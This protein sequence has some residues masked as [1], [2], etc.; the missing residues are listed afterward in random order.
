ILQTCAPEQGFVL[1]PFSPAIARMAGF[2]HW[3]L[4]LQTP[5]KKSMQQWLVWGLPKLR[6]AL[7]A[8]KVHWS[9]DVDPQQM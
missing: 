7:L 4:I 8:N 2:F 5:D 9:V 3:Q 1:G 6:S